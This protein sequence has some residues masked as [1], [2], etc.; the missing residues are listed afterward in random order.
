MKSKLSFM[1]IAL[2]S[3]ALGSAH[4]VNAAPPTKACSL[5]TQAQVSAALG[6]KVGAGRSIM[7]PEVCNW[8][9]PFRAGAPPIKVEL[10]F[11][12]P[13]AFD[14]AK[15]GVGYR[16]AKTTEVRGIGDDAVYTSYTNPHE[17]PILTVKKGNA[18]FQIAVTGFSN[19]QT[20]AKEKTLAVEVCS[21]L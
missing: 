14:A 12:I 17:P 10:N 8:P 7:G 11:V 3:L 6:V 15:K 5:L 9:G 4:A 18:A 2:V 21:K 13:T 1:V 20:K 16:V 19:D